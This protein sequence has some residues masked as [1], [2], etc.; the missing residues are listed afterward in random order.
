MSYP[1]RY[2]IMRSGTDARIQLFPAQLS[3]Q[4]TVD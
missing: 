4:A 1:I 2:E 3:L